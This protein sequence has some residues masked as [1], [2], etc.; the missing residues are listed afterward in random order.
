M[1]MGCGRGRQRHTGYWLAGT[2]CFAARITC[3]SLATG[4][5][6]A[7]PPSVDDDPVGARRAQTAASGIATAASSA[8]RRHSF[9]GAT[10]A[11]IPARRAEIAGTT[12]ATRYEKYGAYDT[13]RTGLPL[14]VNS[15]AYSAMPHEAS[16]SPVERW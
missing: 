10:I 8:V 6:P 4:A 13:V 11:F 14:G 15:V 5:T 2:S 7:E 3:A 12:G 1:Q 16:Q 9:S